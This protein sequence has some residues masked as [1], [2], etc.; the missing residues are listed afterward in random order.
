MPSLNRVQLIGYLGKDPESRF[1]STGKEYTI[2]SLAVGRHW[3]NKD[4]ELQSETEWFNIEA[5]SRLAE[6]C[7]QYLQKGSLVYLEGRLHTSRYEQKGEIHYFTKVIIS[8]MQMLD[9][10]AGEEPAQVEDNTVE[11]PF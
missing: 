9:R 3:K 8:S 7:R 2:F 4:G 1:T 11:E 6:I 10:K 5:W